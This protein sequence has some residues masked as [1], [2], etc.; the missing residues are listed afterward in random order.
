MSDFFHGDDDAVPC[1]HLDLGIFLYAFPVG[2]DCFPIVT[3][4]QDTPEATLFDGLGHFPLFT[5][6]GVGVAHPVVFIP[7]Q[8]S[9]SHRPDEID[10]E[11]RAQRQCDELGYDTHSDSG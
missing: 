6:D 1:H 5:K 11:E 10:A 4:S 8:V 7:M 9:E 3:A 2:G